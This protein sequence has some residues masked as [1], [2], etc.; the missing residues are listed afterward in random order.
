MRIKLLLTCLIAIGEIA[1]SAHAEILNPRPHFS[2]ADAKLI[3]GNSLLS[4]L[5]EADPW[6]VRRILNLADMRG[7]RAGAELAAAASDGFAGPR[8]ETNRDAHGSIAWFEVVAQARK[9]RDALKRRA[10]PA[11]TNQ[12]ADNGTNRSAAESVALLDMMKKARE[13]KSAK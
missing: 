4:A 3:A 12:N 13:T 7:P 10:R 6:L 1:S 9:E 5:L 2:A 8:D 11:G